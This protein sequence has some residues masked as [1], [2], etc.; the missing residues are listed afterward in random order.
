MTLLLTDPRFVLHKTGSHPERPLRLERIWAQLERSG[1]AKECRAVP[2]TPLTPEQLATVHEPKVIEKARAVAEAG[3]GLLDAD[4]ILSAESYDIARLAAGA[5]VAAVDAVLRGNHS[6]ALCLI[7]P[8]GHHACPDQSMG[9]CLFNN[10]ALAARHARDAF[11]LTRIL[12][13]DWDVH[14]GNGTQ[15]VFYQNGD[16]H[17]LSIHRYGGGFYPGTGAANE[18][19]TGRGLG[20]IRNEPIRFGITRPDFLARFRSV[21]GDVADRCKPELI[22]L[23]AGFDAHVRDPVGSLGLETEDFTE[24]T[25]FLLQVAAAHSGGRLVSCLEGGYDVDALAESVETHLDE[26]LHYSTKAD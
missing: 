12:V 10:I 25:R 21:V 24:M 9:F 17:F 22:L 6:R 1:L 2:F 20:K 14:H 18:T 23:S 11:G 16:A 13:L 5:G 19:G 7:R 3:G 15:D 8:P 26:L 4:T